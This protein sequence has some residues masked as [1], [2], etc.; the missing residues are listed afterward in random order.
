MLDYRG[1]FRVL[2]ETDKR[3]GKVC[4]FTFIPCRVRKGAN[5][6]RY[7]D[8]ML[9]VYIP[10]KPTVNRLLT[11]HPEIFKPLQIGDTEGTLLFPESMI[12]AV[13]D[14]LKPFVMGKNK[15]PRPKRKV[16]ISEE[17]KQELS[18]RMKELHRNKVLL[19]R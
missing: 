4:E 6:C 18:N 1:Q 11:E 9:N 7:S 8:T 2:Y 3:T 12:G 16:I 5:I 17:R 14:I 10:G 19:E 13:V 15:S